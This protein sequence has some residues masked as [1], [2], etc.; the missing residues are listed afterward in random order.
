MGIF[1]FTKKKAVVK[2]I[3][4]PVELTIPAEVDVMEF[5]RPINMTSKEFKTITEIHNE[6]DTAQD[7]LYEEATSILTK[8]KSV[9]TPIDAKIEST[10]N[11]LAAIGFVNSPA[12]K[13]VQ[14]VN[15]KRFANKVALVKTELEATMINNYRTNYPFLKFL[16]VSELNRICEKYGLIYAPVKNYIKDVPE[17]NI[18][19]IEDAQSLRV[20]DAEPF[21]YV[22]KVTKFY[23]TCPDEIREILKNEVEYGQAGNSSN[24]DPSESV[25]LRIVKEMGYTGDYKGWIFSNANVSKVN[26]VGLFICAPKSHFDLS[27]LSQSGTHAFLNI[28]KYEIKD[29]IV[30]RYCKGGVQ[31]LSKWGLEASDEA[32][33]NPIDN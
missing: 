17:K 32:L 33:L 22:V 13:Q 10:G 6:F 23:I 16:T 30:F 21:K 8:L 4:M 5:V 14:I 1:N 9:S 25:L 18:K 20:N 31:V 19:M 3:V 29:P 11:R 15:N 7:R 12:A 28:Q 2:E 26:Q 24:S 27:G